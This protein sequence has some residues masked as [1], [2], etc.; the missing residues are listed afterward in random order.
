M[1]LKIQ[2]TDFP[3]IKFGEREIEEGTRARDQCFYNVYREHGKKCFLF[4]L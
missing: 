3:W 4:L 2:K 1:I